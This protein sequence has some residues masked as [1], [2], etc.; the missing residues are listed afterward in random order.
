M[1]DTMLGEG[2]RDEGKIEREN[3]K[4]EKRKRG[5]EKERRRE[6]EKER[7][8]GSEMSGCQALDETKKSNTPLQGPDALDPSSGLSK[9]M[10]RNSERHKPNAQHDSTMTAP[11]ST[12]AFRGWCK[13]GES[14]VLSASRSRDMAKTCLR[15]QLGSD[16]L[17]LQCISGG[18]DGG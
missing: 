16:C 11:P 8:K 15:L 7:G 9:A 12:T 18:V 2:R 17:Q 10:T 1:K 5:K 4:E 3:V 14:A 13:Y 6:G